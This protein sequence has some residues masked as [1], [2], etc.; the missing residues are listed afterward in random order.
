M[1]QG[2]VHWD[3]VKQIHLF[4]SEQSLELSKSNY[5]IHVMADRDNIHVIAERDNIHVIPDREIPSELMSTADC[6]Q[7]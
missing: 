5:K 3:H 7:H 2:T 1:I 6:L 4:I